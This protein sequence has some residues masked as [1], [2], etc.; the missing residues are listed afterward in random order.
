MDNE[1]KLGD[2]RLQTFVLCSLI[3]EGQLGVSV[4]NVEPNTHFVTIGKV[5][6]DDSHFVTIGKV[7]YDDSHFVT[8]GKVEYD[9]S[10]SVET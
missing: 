1:E 10:D 8:I 4:Q 2:H 7:E 3:L 9:D 6:Y 5:E